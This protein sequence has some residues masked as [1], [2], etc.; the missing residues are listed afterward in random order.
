MLSSPITVNSALCLASPVRE[1]FMIGAPVQ[2]G[3]TSSSRLFYLIF[4][5]FKAQGSGEISSQ[6]HWSLILVYVYI[7]IYFSP[8]SLPL[9]LYQKD[10][11]FTEF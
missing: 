3:P 10:K 2:I 1:S 4:L 7:Y 5:F 8:L 9:L 6:P 11:E